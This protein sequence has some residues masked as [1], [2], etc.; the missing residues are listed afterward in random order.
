M[1]LNNIYS[2]RDREIYNKSILEVILKNKLTFYDQWFA[3]YVFWGIWGQSRP[4]KWVLPH[5][6][7]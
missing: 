1:G 5:P 4:K 3:R 7:A 2:S 6:L